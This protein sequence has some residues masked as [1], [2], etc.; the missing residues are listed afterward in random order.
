MAGKNANQ[1]KLI[2][3]KEADFTDSIEINGTHYKLLEQVK[4]YTYQPKPNTVQWT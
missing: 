4:T 3:L 2:A 1:E